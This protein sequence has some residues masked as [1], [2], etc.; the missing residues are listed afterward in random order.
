[1]RLIGVLGGSFDPIH[2]GHLIAGAILREVLGA[3]EIR[4]VPTGQQPFKVGRHAASA[5]DRAR[6]VEL[7][8]GGTAGF[9]VDRYE[10]DR[11]GPSYTVETLADLRSRCPDDRL[12]LLIG[13]DAAAL[14]PSWRDPAGI[15]AQAE[16]VVFSRGGQSPPDGVADRVVPVPFLDISSTALRA[17]VR[18]GR[19]IRYFVPDPVSEYIAARRL[20]QD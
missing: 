12:C 17:R 15:R 6:M 19:S 16:V 5:A 7:A 1:V 8:V 14:F 11:P 10:A 2:H 9:V 3:D 20:Y 18:A 13:T 4:W